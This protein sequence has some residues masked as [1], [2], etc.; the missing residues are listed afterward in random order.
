MY[1]NIHIIYSFLAD[2][3][4]D[5]DELDIPVNAVATALKGFFSDLTEPLIP[6]YLYEEL[7]E[8]AG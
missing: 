6:S 2:P 1:L 5:I 8:A 3:E 7:I 4:T